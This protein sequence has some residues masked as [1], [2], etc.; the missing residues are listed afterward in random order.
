MT[1]LSTLRPEHLEC[2]SMGHAWS[3]VDDHDH[4]QDLRTG[5][6][7]RFRR[8]EQCLRCSAERTREVDLGHPSAIEVR[9]VRM[10]YP[11]GY[12]L[13]EPRLRVT[14]A[15]ALGAQYGREVAL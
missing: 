1:R 3:H 2:R 10:K 8:D 11:E 5:D 14:R 9:T 7:I 13:V 15:L 4:L 12:V 6:I